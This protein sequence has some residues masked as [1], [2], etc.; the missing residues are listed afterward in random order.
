[1]INNKTFQFLAGCVVIFLSFRLWQEGWI[2]GYLAVESNDGSVESLDLVAMFIS[3]AVSA[4]QM[5][6][7]VA[8]GIFQPL[9]V[10]LIGQMKSFT[11]TGDASVTTSEIDTSELNR[12]L[13]DIATRLTKLESTSNGD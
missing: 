9:I 12:V 3:A 8:I 5:V 1:M 7:L 13:T 11:T 4:V 6:G 2:D 10:G